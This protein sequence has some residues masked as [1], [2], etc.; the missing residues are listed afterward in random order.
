MQT[1]ALEN[2]MWSDVTSLGEGRGN[3]KNVR[4]SLN[5]DDFLKLLL[6]ELKY[7]DPLNPTDDKQFIAQ[8]AQFSSLEQM[9]N[10]SKSMSMAQSYS[11]LGKYV[12]ASRDRNDGSEMEGVVDAVIMKSGVPYIKVG[13]D[14]AMLDA[15]RVVTQDAPE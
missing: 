6:T 8:M 13:S 12:K 10:I 15:V 2:T 5:K 3:E 1:Q 11:L 14:E 7:Q 9:Q 4:G